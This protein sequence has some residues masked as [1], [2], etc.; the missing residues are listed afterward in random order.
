VRESL[1]RQLYSSLKAAGRRDVIE[2]LRD[3]KLSLPAYWR[4][5]GE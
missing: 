5:G 2:I 3:T 1:Y 4:E